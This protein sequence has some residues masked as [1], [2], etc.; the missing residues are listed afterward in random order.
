MYIFWLVLSP[1]L[2]F[3]SNVNTLVSSQSHTGNYSL[4][5]SCTGATKRIYFLPSIY[6]EVIPCTEFSR[7]YHLYSHTIGILTFIVCSVMA[8][9]QFFNTLFTKKMI[10]YYNFFTAVLFICR[11]S[12]VY[13]QEESCLF[14][15][16]VL[17]ICRRSLVYL[18][19]ESCLFA[20][21]VLFI[22]RRSLVY[23]QEESCL[24]AGGVLFICR[25]S[26]VICRTLQ[27]AASPSLPDK[28][29]SDTVKV[30]YRWTNLLKWQ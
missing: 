8:F 2:Y 13:L 22:C 9:V 20:G 6:Y 15:G 28:T 24:F 14:A 26:L 11:R 7:L 25:R 30:F 19:E 12:L 29:P 23:L 16:G 5:R 21:G 17:F 27:F 4:T 3:C 10:W 1:S 18:Q